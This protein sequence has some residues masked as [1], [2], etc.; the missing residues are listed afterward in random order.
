VKALHQSS[1]PKSLDSRLRGNDEQSTKRKLNYKDIRELEQLPVRIET[2]ETQI[3]E[4]TAAMQSPDFYRQDAA[5]ITAF[6]AQ[7]ADAQSKLDAAYARWQAL[8]I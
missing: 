7:L 6:N 4:L 5:T 2:L 1:K 8:E 3:A